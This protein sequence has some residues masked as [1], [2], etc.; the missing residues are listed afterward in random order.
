MSLRRILTKVLSLAASRGSSIPSAEDQLRD[1]K[2][3]SSDHFLPKEQ[4]KKNPR[5]DRRIL[6]V[7]PEHLAEDLAFQRVDV[8]GVL[9]QHRPKK[10]PRERHVGWPRPPHPPQEPGGHLVHVLQQIQGLLEVVLVGSSV[11]VAD[12][13][14]RRGNA[15]VSARRPRLDTR[16]SN[17]HLLVVRSG[18]SMGV[19]T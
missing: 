6:L 7:S 9:L 4:K 15:A 14:L 3:Q 18:T 8:H 11:V 5:C 2:R 16:E 1:T 12:V 17:S 10:N 13:Q 19:T